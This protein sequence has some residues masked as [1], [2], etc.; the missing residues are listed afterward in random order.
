MGRGRSRQGPVAVLVMWALWGGCRAF[1]CEVEPKWMGGV[2]QS[3][4]QWLLF[5]SGDVDALVLLWS[6]GV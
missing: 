6:S 3:T 4:R 1:G 2:S 5:W